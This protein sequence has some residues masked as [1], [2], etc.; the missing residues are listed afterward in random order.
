[1]NRGQSQETSPLENAQALAAH[2]R[3]LSLARDYLNDH[4]DQIHAI[5]REIERAVQDLSDVI[6]EAST[7][8]RTHAS[9]AVAMLSND[10]E[11]TQ[12]AAYAAGYMKTAADS[13]LS[14]RELLMHSRTGLDRLSWP[15]HD[16]VAAEQLAQFTEL[17]GKRDEDL[18]PDDHPNP[19]TRSLRRPDAIGS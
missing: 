17:L 1:M 8:C 7:S 18:A 3:E 15:Q 13:A 16:P 6:D 5:L 4:P 10:A 12:E 14:L 2:A 19:G 11:G 9:T